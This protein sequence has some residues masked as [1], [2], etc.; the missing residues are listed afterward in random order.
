[1]RPLEAVLWLVG[2]GAEEA[3]PAYCLADL[4]P[5]ENARKGT[6]IPRLASL[7]RPR[8][9]GAGR[10]PRR[11]LALGNRREPGGDLGFQS[12]PYRKKE[13]EDL[14]DIV[15]QIVCGSIGLKVVSHVVHLCL[16]IPFSQPGC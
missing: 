14:N 9:I 6:V 12:S 2:A 5:V 13:V 10:S 16:W 3:L 15:I 11:F 4:S 7:Q 1:M 8:K